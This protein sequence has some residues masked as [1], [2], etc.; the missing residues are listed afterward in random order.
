MPIHTANGFVG[1]DRR[2]KADKVLNVAHDMRNIRITAGGS[3][4]KRA[5][6]KLLCSLTGEIEGLW[7]GSLGGSVFLLASANGRLYKIDTNGNAREIGVIGEG[8]CLFFEFCGRVYIM[9]SA[10][11][12]SYDGSTL[13][14]IEGYIPL[15]AVGCMPNGEGTPFEEINMLTDKRRQRFSPDGKSIL[16]KLAEEDIDEIVSV[17]VGGAVYNGNYSLNRQTSELSF[18]QPIPAG[19]DSLEITYKKQS[20]TRKNILNCKRAMLFGGNSDGRIFLYSNPEKPNC[21]FYS[22]LADG[23]P[24]AEYFPINCYTVIGSS[25]ISCIVQQYDRQLIFTKNEAFYSYCE[26]ITDNSGRRISSFPVFSLNNGKGCLFET[27]GCVIA[28]RPVTLC[29]DGLNMWEST[30]VEN[31]KNALPF[32]QPINDLLATSLLQGES[33]HLA[34]L[35]SESELFFIVNGNAYV[36]NYGIGCWY[37]YDGFGGKGFKVYRDTLYFTNGSG[38]YCYSERGEANYVGIWQSNYITHEGGNL[39]IVSLCS[40]IRVKGNIR[41]KFIFETANGA[42]SEKGVELSEESEKYMRIS[43]RPALKRALPFRLSIHIEGEGELTLHSLT[44]KTRK[45]ERS[46]RIGLLQREAKA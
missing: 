29:G 17:T 18:E 2:R 23:V 7:C 6:T 20:T 1:I 21:R 3:L 19:L 39:D 34:D 16:Y 25:P 28:N 4:E 14:E 38:I 5:K 11:Y 27:D 24:S 45:K 37:I 36:Y 44:V 43:L 40:D 8:E 15:V 30:G 32:S 41:L 9:N 31:E 13:T 35:Q 22:A 10:Y 42:I 12:G 26:L 46:R 33:L